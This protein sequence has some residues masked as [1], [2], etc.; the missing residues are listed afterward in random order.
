MRALEGAGIAARRGA[1][2]FVAGHVE[3]GKAVGNVIAI[4]E[5][6][7]EG[8]KAMVSTRAK[9]VKAVLGARCVATPMRYVGVTG[10]DGPALPCM[11]T[12]RE[13]L[14]FHRNCRC[15]MHDDEAIM[16]VDARRR[17]RDCEQ[18]RCNDDKCATKHV[19]ERSTR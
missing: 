12:R 2:Q 7:Y 16:Q 5:F 9:H 6:G 4:A 14:D 15:V 10:G 18:A 8:N 19:R 3:F 13:H 17:G 1:I 11:S